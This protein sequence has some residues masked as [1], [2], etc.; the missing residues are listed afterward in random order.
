MRT[1]SRGAKGK[2]FHLDLAIVEEEA[3]QSG[4]EGGVDG[5]ARRHQVAHDRL[6]IGARCVI[7]LGAQLC[8]MT[9]LS[10]HQPPP[11]Q[12]HH[13]TDQCRHRSSLSTNPR[14]PLLPASYT[15]SFLILTFRLSS[16][17][18][19]SFPVTT[20]PTFPAPHHNGPVCDRLPLL[21]PLFLESTFIIVIF[22]LFFDH[23]S[24]R[25]KR[26]W[27]RSSLR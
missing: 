13:Q 3:E 4:R 26:S 23:K 12:R 9:D 2:Q 24:S 17:F 7:E 8:A 16:I 11:A 5:R 20:P 22:F 21:P 15:E 25:H 14:G 27:V 1:K 10:A 19:F 18:L 6:C